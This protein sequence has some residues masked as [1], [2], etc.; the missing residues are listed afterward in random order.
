MAVSITPSLDYQ[1]RELAAANKVKSALSALRTEAQAKQWTFQV[2]YTTALDFAIEEIT[3]LK[4]PENWLEAAKAQNLK[5]QLMAAAQRVS[6]GACAAN[7]PAFNWADHN[8]VTGVRDQGPCGSCWAFG[9][10]GAFEGSYAL[11]NNAMIDSAEQDTLDCSGAGSCGGGWWAF[12]NLIDKGSAKE[13]DYPYTAHQG[14]CQAGVNRPYQA[15]A[16]GYVD[17]TKEI[18]SVDALKQALCTYGPIAVAVAATPAFQAYTGGVFNEHSTAGINHAITLVGWDDS[19]K[20]WRIKNSWGTGWGESGFMWIAYDSNQIGYG[21]AWVQAKLAP[22]CEDGPSLI[23]YQE[24]YW[25]PSPEVFSSNAVVAS[26]TFTLPKEMFV[27]IVADGSA[28]ITQGSVPRNFTTGIYSTADPNVIWT[29]SYRQGTFEAANQHLP[30]HSSMGLK[31]PAGTYT[32]Y[33][34]IWLGGYTVQFDSGTITVLAV[35]CSMG[36]RLQAAGGGGAMVATTAGE[37]MTVT[38]RDPNQ[39][40]LFITHD[41]SGGT[42]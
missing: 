15:A 17:A 27:S 30:V 35:P 5:A 38:S 14:T 34:K 2:G 40:D 37:Q 8:G 12:Q 19:K 39:P 16:W 7:L 10:H 1:K 42:H 18:P 31:L 33:W 21:A 13:T 25:A 20:A 24:F 22:T 23:A 11:L 29:A 26:V 6:L 41:R 32:M 28:A 36:G 4:P 3:G 9:T